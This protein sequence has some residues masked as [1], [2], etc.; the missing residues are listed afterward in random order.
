MM[1]CQDLVTFNEKH[2]FANNE[3]NRDGDN[4]NNSWNHGVEGPT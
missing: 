1:V 2:N 4:H 3:Q